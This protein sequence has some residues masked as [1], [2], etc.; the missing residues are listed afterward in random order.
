M[1]LTTSLE[2]SR[3]YFIQSVYKL[4]DYA[5][6]PLKRLRDEFLLL[7]YEA[8]YPKPVLSASEIPRYINAEEWKEREQAANRVLEEWAVS[9]ALVSRNGEGKEVPADWLVDFARVFC[10]ESARSTPNEGVLPRFARTEATMPPPGQG[11]AVLV[12]PMDHPDRLPGET[13]REFERRAKKAVAAD[14]K[15][16]RRVLER[17]SAFKPIRTRET[18]A[19]PLDHFEWFILYQCCRWKL[20]EIKSKYANTGDPASPATPSTGPGSLQTIWMGISSAAARTGLALIA[21]RLALKRFR[22]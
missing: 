18:K 6:S 17:L 9:C 14:V 7:W 12:I 5:G 19:A 15:R 13:W 21:R 11:G 20:T 8:K 4:D 2:A 3:R 10:E 22:R 16:R 1:R